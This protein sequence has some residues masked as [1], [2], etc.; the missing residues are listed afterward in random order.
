[1]IGREITETVAGDGI[2]VTGYVTGD[3]GEGKSEAKRNHILISF[4][5]EGLVP[6]P[7]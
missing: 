2:V 7:N 3:E 1:M 6:G 5:A 4:E